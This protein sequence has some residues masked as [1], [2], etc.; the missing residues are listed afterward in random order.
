MT[1]AWVDT[2]SILHANSLSGK[3]W[4]GCAAF[5][6]PRPYSISNKEMPAQ[7]QAGLFLDTKG[8]AVEVTLVM[9]N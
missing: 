3:K 7:A 2:S 8:C 4:R 6:E 9:W 5:G 1:D